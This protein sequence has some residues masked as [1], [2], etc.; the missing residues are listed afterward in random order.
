M[1]KVEAGRF[2]VEHEREASLSRPHQPTFQLSAVG[3]TRTNVF[4]TVH[5]VVHQTFA[6]ENF[7]QIDVIVLGDVGFVR[8]FTEHVRHEQQQ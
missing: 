8:C 1:I 6:A 5:V 3:R 2:M 7:L 4:Q